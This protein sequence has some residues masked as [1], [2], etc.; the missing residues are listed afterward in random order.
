MSDELEVIE[1]GNTGANAVLKTLTLTGFKSFVQRTHLE[2]APGITAIIGPNGS[3][4][5]LKFSSQVTLADGSRRAIGEIVEE[6][7]ASGDVEIVDDGFVARNP[8]TSIDIVSLNPLDLKLE[9]RS[10]TAY[11]KRTAPPKMLRVHTRAGRRVDVT[12]YHPL[13]TIDH[14]R[15]RSLRASEVKTGAYV[16]LPRQLPLS[17]DRAAMPFARSVE[18][19]A[20]D[21]RITVP[22]STALATWGASVALDFGGYSAWRR[23]A[24]LAPERLDDPRGE[25]GLRVPS[26]MA[27]CATAGGSPPIE[28]RL[29]ARNGNS[30]RVPES[31]N[32]DLARFLGLAI[33]EGENVEAGQLRFVNNE[34]PVTDEFIRLAACLF[35]VPTSR[36]MHSNGRAETTLLTSIALIKLLDHYG[37]KRGSRSAEKSVPPMLFSAPEHVQWSFLSGLFEGDVHVCHRP[38]RGRIQAYVEYAS[39][40]E[41]LV[42]DVSSLLLRLGVFGVVR[43]KLKRATNTKKGIW[44]RYWSVFVY[45]N[46][47]LRALAENLRFVG[48]KQA[49]LERLRSLTLVSNPNLDVVPTATDLIYDAI[50]LAGVSVKRNRK[51]RAKLAAY[52]ERR[53]HASRQGIREVAAQIEQLG[54]TP[55]AARPI[56]DQ[57]EVLATSDVYWDEVVSVEEFDS[58]DEWVYDLCVEGN[59]NFVAEDM[60]VHNSNVADAIRWALGENNARVLRA[61]RNEEL[62][63]AGSETRRGL[64][65][66]EAILQLDNSSRR[67]PIEFNEI[68]VGRRLFKN[69]EAEYLV[70]RARVRLRDLQ[71]L[72]A[73]ANLA[74]NPFV[75]IGQGLIDQVLA[76]RPS[77]RRTVIEEAAGTRRLHLRREDALQRL[78]H[79]D[80][81]LVRVIDILREIGPRV[82]LLTEQAAKWTEYE[83]IRNDLRRRALRWYRSSFG[84]TA[85]QRNELVAKLVGIDREIERL[86]DYVAE[87]E[88]LATG[89]DDE[90]RSA[91]EVEEKLRIAAADAATA[92]SGLRERIAA[93]AASLEA[94]ASE[95][96]RSRAALASLPAE[97][98]SLRERRATVENEATEAARRARE[99]AAAAHVAE[100]EMSK[101]RVALAEAQAA[102]VETERA[103]V[104]RDGEE[105]RL[106]DEDRA[107]LARDDELSK[108]AAGLAAERAE[109]EKERSRIAREL[110]RARDAATEAGRA[111]EGAA[112]RAGAARNDLQR[113]DGDLALLRGQASALREAV[114]R[115]TEELEARA[116]GSAPVALPKGLRW[117]HE[118]LEI[119]AN[120]RLA[121][122]AVLGDAVAYPSDKRGLADLQ[123]ATGVTIVVPNERA[124]LA[125]PDGCS[126]LIDHLR[127]D[128]DVK[129]IAG[130]LFRNVFVGPREAA[131]R[132][133][134]TMREGIVVTHDGMV[135]TPGT[136]H[137]PDD[138]VASVQK[139]TERIV[140]MQRRLGEE[141]NASERALVQLGLEREAS[142]ARLADAEAKLGDV[143]R[144][145]GGLEI[146]ADALA[147]TEADVRDL[148]RA[149]EARAVA[150]ERERSEL[151]ARREQLGVSRDAAKRAT[152]AAAEAFGGAQRDERVAVEAH[153]ATTKRAEDAR[154]DAATSEERRSSLVR[155]RDT[156]DEQVTATEKRIAEED[157]RL[158]AL[159]EQERD[160]KSRLGAAQEQLGVA[161]ANTKEAARSADIARERSLA[162]EGSRRESEQRLAKARE[163]LAELRGERS[164]VG[165]E[166]ERAS[167][168]L[169]LLEEQV[170]AELGLPDEEPLPDPESIEVDDE[171]TDD[172]KANALRD[173]Q[174]LR[175][176]LIALEPVNPLAAVE[177][178][179]VG[180]RHR[181]LSEQRADLEKAMADLRSLADDLA[182]TIAEQFSATFQAVDREFNVFFQRLFNGGQ[183]SLRTS[184]D[185]DEPGIDI[186]ARPPGKRIGSLAQLSGGERALTATALLLAILRVKPTPFCVL[187]E[188]DAA[189]DERNVG[190]FTEALRELTD[191][192]QFVV[193]THNRKTIEAADTLYGV[194]MDEGGSSKVLSMRLADVDER[195]VG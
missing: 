165:V 161:A 33:A 84:T 96:D 156:L 68:E 192:T 136:I 138:R 155:L 2:F 19:F 75:V 67:L 44:R 76:L 117:L 70:N 158:R 129:A 147:A 122:R 133:A 183:A 34:R 154:L 128:D 87:T 189:L 92:E 55:E 167:G 32:P 184:D 1:G 5:C 111:T 124:D 162:A 115:A 135:V 171:G 88:T 89:T 137:L 98:A 15:M 35:Q 108:Q 152:A 106:A 127:L 157:A 69:G 123:G 160:A 114:A 12:P 119:P 50:K 30:I 74:D 188:V 143:Q 71:D 148:V 85:A 164:K 118:R 79:A 159:I 120:L 153:A 78:K 45:G 13:F 185:P 64:G 56:L 100:E 99:S 42:R 21:P 77:D 193:I 16:A 52:S 169:K 105:V 8:R 144:E 182:S 113:V 36:L 41:E 27:L 65:M 173:L 190:R 121:V 104:L 40:S 63:F 18:A 37:L 146:A 194:S 83:I 17:G 59:H 46:E 11:V 4:K 151:I 90:L 125:V 24:G 94:V 23:A 91:R 66:A 139:A 187:D 126:R 142:A 140:A 112:E 103:H 51:G 7:L 107:L 53:C 39:A 176:K 86:A 25:I 195:A 101:T 168:A 109:R 57:L 29:R 150:V 116:T 179:E 178:G 28:N 81:E 26:F 166:E 58:P 186:Y 14:G 6:A 31:L 10:V 47:Q 131:Y 22:S 54:A 149:G 141:L 73:G 20:D 145:R 49:A 174:R 9:P 93:L 102:R 38:F 97:A 132:A 48:E 80:V 163:R 172:E 62:I 3:G 95:R 82:E 110:E 170:R 61:K 134:S 130:A 175:R 177:L 60:I 181:F 43:S 191:R 72:L 180:E